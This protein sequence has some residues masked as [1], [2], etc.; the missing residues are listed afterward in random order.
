MSL[1]RLHAILCMFPAV[2]VLVEKQII[3][4]FLLELF[5]RALSW[6]VDLYVFYNYLDW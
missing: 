1:S 2:L 4:Y 3:F 6:I 5:L